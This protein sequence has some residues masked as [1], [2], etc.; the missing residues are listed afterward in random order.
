MRS[1]EE[2]DD[3]DEIGVVRSSLVS[4]RQTDIFLSV[5]LTKHF[6]F[7]TWTPHNLGFADNEWF[8]LNIHSNNPNPNPN[9]NPYF[10]YESLICQR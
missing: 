9:P 8:D 1:M 10:V 7:L 3:I 6:T 4:I 2:R 5:A